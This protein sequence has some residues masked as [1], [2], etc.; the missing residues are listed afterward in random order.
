[1]WKY[2]EPKRI[3]LGRGNRQERESV[4]QRRHISEQGTRLAWSFRALS[5][6]EFCHKAYL[7]KLLQLL[8]GHG[9]VM[10]YLV[11]I[12]GKFDCLCP[13]VNEGGGSRCRAKDRKR[14]SHLSILVLFPGRNAIGLVRARQPK[15]PTL[16]RY[17]LVL[18]ANGR[19]IYCTHGYCQPQYQFKR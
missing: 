11:D 15:R 5:V 18:H 8:P 1:M 17:C 13:V 3:A 19:I 7:L 10:V 16:G 12:A 9:W 14:L 6:R 2:T 4:G